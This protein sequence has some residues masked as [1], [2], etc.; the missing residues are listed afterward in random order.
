[1]LIII[2]AFLIIDKLKSLIVIKVTN[3]AF[4]YSTFNVDARFFWSA[5]TKE[6]LDTP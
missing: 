1:M 3:F 2:W 6:I 5:K 4:A